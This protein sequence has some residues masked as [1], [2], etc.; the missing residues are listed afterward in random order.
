MTTSYNEMERDR[1]RV[2]RANTLMAEELAALTG[3]LE[4]AADALRVQNVRFEAALGQHV[5]G[6]VFAGCP[7]APHRQQS[8]LSADLR[9]ALGGRDTR[10]FDRRSPGR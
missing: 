6:P 9:S 1:R 3:D 7:G 2:D 10:S 8:A 5:T 4:R